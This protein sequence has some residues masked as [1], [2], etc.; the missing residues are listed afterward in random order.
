L[1]CFLSDTPHRSGININSNTPEVDRRHFACDAI[2]MPPFTSGVKEGRPAAGETESDGEDDLA[3]NTHKKGVARGLSW[4]DQ[5]GDYAD[6]SDGGEFVHESS[7][8]DFGVTYNTE[9][10]TV[11]ERNETL[12]NIDEA[13]A[14]H[15][16]GVAQKQEEE[17]EDDASKT[18]KKTRKKITFEEHVE[19]A[20]SSPSMLRTPRTLSTRRVNPDYS[21]MDTPSA[22]LAETWMGAATPGRAIE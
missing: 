9:P 22:A 2:I 7:H 13:A 12:D 3:S 11:S 19:S 8:D 6:S 1:L 18:T 4:E 20:A 16:S 17:K 10:R 14:S 5:E 15:R 21:K